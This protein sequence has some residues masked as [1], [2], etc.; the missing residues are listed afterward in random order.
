MSAF[1]PQLT[2][3]EGEAFGS[4]KESLE[5]DDEENFRATTLMDSSGVT[6]QAKERELANEDG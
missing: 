4:V 3:E 5:E 2:Q 6:C 1:D